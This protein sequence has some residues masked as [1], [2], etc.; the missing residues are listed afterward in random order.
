MIM[1]VEQMVMISITCRGVYFVS[2]KMKI[3]DMIYNIQGEWYV[4]HDLLIL[5]ADSNIVNTSFF[6]RS[7]CRMFARHVCNRMRMCTSVNDFA[8]TRAKNL[9]KTQL[10]QQLDGSTPTCEDIGR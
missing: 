6:N 1:N 7:V 4:R 3:D 5:C 9:L 8:V 10:L 2:D